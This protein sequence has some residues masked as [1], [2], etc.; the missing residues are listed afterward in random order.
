MENVVAGKPMNVVWICSDEHNKAMMGCTGHPDLVTPNLD[1]LAARGVRFAN[2]YCNNTIC[3][4]SR[5]SMAT[6]RY[7]HRIGSWDNSTPYTGEPPSWGHRLLEAGHEVTTIGKL[8]YR[9]VEDDS[10]F[11][12]QR[13]SLHVVDGI[14]D[15][16]SLIREEMPVR[17]ETRKKILG[18]GPGESSYTRYDRG[19]TEE[20]VRF[21]QERAA[22]P[23]DKPWAVF[24]SYVTPH[25]PLICPEQFYRLYDQ[26]RLEWPK[27]YSFAERPMHPV[28]EE[29]RR[30][31]DLTDELP[32]PVVRKA[33]A[34]YYGLCS[35]MDAQVGQVLKA[36]KDCGLEGDTLVMYTSDHGD[37]AGKQGLWF[38][39]T[40]YE[41]SAGTPFIMAG[42]GLP[43]GVVNETPVSL[44]DCFPTILDAVGV[45]QEAD[46]AAELDGQ[47][48]LPIARGEAQPERTMFCEYHASASCTGIFMI[49]KGRYKYVHYV[50]YEPQLFDLE[51]DPD[52]LRDLARE[53]DYADVLAACRRELYAVCDPDEVNAQAFGYQQ[54]KIEENG[55]RAALIEAGYSIPYSPVPEQFR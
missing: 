30:V 6:G 23:P 26:E 17:P 8:H 51:A 21:L 32:E 31:W 39:H 41:G 40:M 4:P 19:I 11:P 43:E 10:G 25:F 29:F 49:R 36:I 1:A 37:M 20:A 50:G 38:K 13:I 33:M 24:I 28:L 22:N 5:A 16:F 47:S 55:G 14:G 2:A 46:C 53:A 7:A 27:Q 9:S 42:P 52:E 34:A 48:L 12:D 15:L 45:S 35:F 44:V 18:A 3:V 54:A